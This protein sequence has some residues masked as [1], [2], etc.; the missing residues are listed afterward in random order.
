VERANA[1]IIEGNQSLWE[2]AD[3][4]ARLYN[5]V[6]FERRQAYIHYKRFEWY[7]KH[8]Y[9]KYAPLVGSATAQQI[10][11]KNN[12]AWKSF[13]TLKG[14]KAEGKLPEHITK[15]S[16]PRYWKK[17]GKRELRIIVRNDC[18]RIDGEHLYLPKG[19]K[20]KYKGELKWRGKQGRLEIFYDEVDGVWR[21]LMSVKVEKP[22]LRR[23]S[24]PLYIDLGVVNLATVWFE[25]LKQPIA[26]SGKAVLSDWWYWTRRISKEQS[27]L[28]KNKAKTSKKLRRL[29]RIRQRRFRHAV[30]AMV[31][32]IV[33]NAHKLG[34][35]KIVLGRLK[36]IRDNNHNHKANAMV[37]NFWSFGYIIRRFKEKAEEHG[38]KVE[39][40][41]EYKTSSTCP[42]CKSENVTIKGRLFK[43]LN[44]G[45]EAHRGAVGVLN[46]ARLNGGEVNRVVAHPLL[47]RWNGVRW[48]PKRAMNNGPM[49]ASR[50]KNPTFFSRGSV[51]LNFMGIKSVAL[52]YA[53]IV[54]PR[55]RHGV[56]YDFILKLKKNPRRLEILGDG[57]QKRSFLWVEDAIDA[58]LKA[59]NAS[60]EG[61][62]VYNVGNIDWISVK[63]VAD[64]VATIMGLG[65]VEYVY[66]PVLHGLG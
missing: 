19:L 22:P 45:L 16:M 29:Y 37:N 59:L 61:F 44:C 66:K 13:F 4:C 43:C 53:N 17:N 34:V 6:N 25:G 57:E 32:T 49:N 60:D 14:L 38:I 33:E 7:P 12:E 20:L 39:E 27:R 9:V 54:G 52:R 36:G 65:N 58:T 63:E 10:I 48:E 40:K 5:E 21:G 2:L 47:L 30:N 42:S 35:T 55:L 8:L 46:I 24:K 3:N 51:N 62:D 31:K 11:N 56:I 26:Y 28:A 50:S 23:G 18:Y 1:F 64:E 41:S 15:V